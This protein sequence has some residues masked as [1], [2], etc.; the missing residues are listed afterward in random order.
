MPATM[1]EVFAAQT[2]LADATVELV[3]A[4]QHALDEG[5]EPDN[6]ARLAAATSR[7]T[8]MGRPAPAAYEVAL[9]AARTADAKLQ[10][11]IV[12][13][14]ARI[15][16]AFWPGAVE[17]QLYND[18]DSDDDQPVIRVAQLS[19]YVGN[20]RMTVDRPA[21]LDNVYDEVIPVVGGYH[22]L[23]IDSGEVLTIDV[24]TGQRLPG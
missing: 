24:L 14:V 5:L 8:G 21:A 10:D 18:A 6:W 9:A 1:H 17:V 12:A 23:R 13:E 19:A 20:V 4:A 16:R 7:M 22:G 2:G 15:V 11:A 3:V